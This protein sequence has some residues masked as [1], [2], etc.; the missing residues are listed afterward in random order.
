[1]A[2]IAFITEVCATGSL[3]QLIYLPNL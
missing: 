1:M 3:S 2:K